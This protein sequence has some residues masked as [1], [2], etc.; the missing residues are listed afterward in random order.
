MYCTLTSSNNVAPL[1]VSIPCERNLMDDL[2]E[3]VEL[4]Q[5]LWGSQKWKEKKAAITCCREEVC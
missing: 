4:F 5:V 2:E 3:E 1:T